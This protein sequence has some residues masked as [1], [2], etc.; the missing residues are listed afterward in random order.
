[1]K[2]ALSIDWIS[3]TD[4]S[5]ELT[6]K[7]TAH[8]ALH[9]WENWESA[10]GTNG[11]TSGAKHA[12][13]TK[14]Y[15]NP[16]RPDMGKHIIY[17]GK[18][19]QRINKMYN[20]NS[21]SVLKH[22]IDSGHTIARIDIALDFYG[23]SLDVMDFQHAFLHGEASTRLRSASVIKSLTDRGHTFYIGSKKRRKKLVRIYDKSAEMNWDFNCIRVEVQLMGKPATKV[24]IDAIRGES[25]AGV[26]LGAMKDVINFPLISEWNKAMASSKDI[27]IGTESEMLGDTQKWLEQTVRM[28]LIKQ[29]VL[30]L[31][32]WTQYKMDIDIQVAMDSSPPMIME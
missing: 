16:K 27:K 13:G 25:V 31:N 4:H 26:L 8:P 1:M 32:W 5:N 30:D 11:Y 6:P 22:H 14:L 2:T 9:D 21:I 20:I 15:I 7:Y 28:C 23:G 3:A 24:S 17:S 29:S 19:L 10:N 12:T 18:T